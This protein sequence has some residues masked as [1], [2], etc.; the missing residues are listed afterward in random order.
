MQNL[1]R[2]NTQWVPKEAKQMSL[3]NAPFAS[4]Q[5]DAYVGFPLHSVN[6]PPIVMIRYALLLFLSVG[7]IVGCGN[8]EEVDPDDLDD[9]PETEAESTQDEFWSNIEDLCGEA[10]AGE[11]VDSPEDED[12]F[13]GE[14][15]VMHVRQC[16]DSE[17]LIPVHVGDDHSRTWILTKGDDFIRLKHDHREEDGTEEEVSQYGGETADA[18]SATSQSFPAD[19]FTAELIPEAASNVWTMEVDPGETFTYILVREET[20]ARFEFKFDLTESVDTPPAPWGYEDTEPT[21]GS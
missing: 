12:D 6:H 9:E 8:G 21:H 2:N 13:D 17:I 18:G 14:E 11:A 1:S 16:Y 10:F 3:G 19:E 4:K 20:G 7:L 5:I 15:L